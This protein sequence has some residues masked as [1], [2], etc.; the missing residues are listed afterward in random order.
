MA[1]L[2]AYIFIMAMGVFM[3]VK[4]EKFMKN[5]VD[6]LEEKNG[7]TL[8]QEEL[9]KKYKTVRI[10]GIVFIVLITIIMFV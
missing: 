8:P 3:I 10:T 9:N 4:P 5:R 6:K 1:N 2:I 7:N